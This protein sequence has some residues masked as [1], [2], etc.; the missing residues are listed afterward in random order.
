LAWRM[1]KITPRFIRISRWVARGAAGLLL[2]LFL[3]RHFRL[4]ATDNVVRSAGYTVIAIFFGA[5]LVLCV[6]GK[7]LQW[8][9][10]PLLRAFGKYS[11]AIYVMHRPLH[12]ILFSLLGFSALTA[13][14][15]FPMLRLLPF[16][17]L[18]P[19]AC[20]LLGKISWVLYERRFLALK[21]LYSY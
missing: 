1:G 5:L 12:P 3:A 14:W 7:Q 10:Q 13:V 2:A 20:L 18:A 19:A 11:Y 9:N 8:L 17:I 6:M 4:D 21:R 15:R 16:L